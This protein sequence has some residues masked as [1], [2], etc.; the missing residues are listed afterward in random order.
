MNEVH[1]SKL[2]VI[3]GATATGK[4]RLA[5]T[6]AVHYNGEII[7][8][9][10]RQVYRGMDL[11]TGKD[12]S[13]YTIDGHIVKH[14]LIDI[15]DPGFEYNIHRF[16]N[17]FRSAYNQIASKGCLPVLCGGSGLYLETALKGLASNDVPVNHGLREE[18]KLL[19]TEQ[20]RMRLEKSKMPHNTTDLN[21]QARLIRAIEIA[22]DDQV[23]HHHMLP[24]LMIG[25]RLERA[26]LREAITQRLEARLR[27]GM[28][29]EI[30]NLLAAGVKPESLLFYGLEYKYLTLFVTGKLTYQE[31]V[32][33]LNTAIH[34]FAKRQETWF[35]RMEKQG[36]VIN[37]IDA[38][39]PFSEIL[40]QANFI[41]KKQ[42]DNA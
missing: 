14:H 38:S 26:K 17:D 27:S 11:G 42:W 3:T 35:R 39:L 5:T 24:H 9:D 20:L 15:H 25:L 8:A 13:E 10:S 21:D 31:A 37:W 1:R 2:L 18:L 6:L 29:S 40:A 19:S 33:L 12:L 23:I 32:S 22:E 4:T 7:S 36:F 41:I 30:E 34:Q 16:G 28:V